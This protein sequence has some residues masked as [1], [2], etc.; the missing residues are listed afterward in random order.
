MDNLLKEAIADAKAVRETALAN[1]KIAL[2]EA[3]TPKLQRMLSAKL[4]QEDGEPEAVE[5]ED[6]EEQADTEEPMEDTSDLPAEE[7]GDEAYEDD[8]VED[9]MSEDE[10]D[11]NDDMEEPMEDTSPMG[12]GEEAEEDEDFEEDEDL[13][14]EDELPAEEDEEAYEDDELDLEAIIR[15][16]EADAEEDEEPVEEQSDSSD[17]GED[18]NVVEPAEG[19]DEEKDETDD[20][21]A[22]PGAENEDDEVVD[23]LDEGEEAEEDEEPLDLESIIKELEDEM[24]GEEAEEDE[25]PAEESAKAK[26]AKVNADLAE[27]RKVVRYL[28]S[29]LHEVNLLNAKLLYTNKLFRAHSLKEN[30]KLRVIETFDRAKN[31]REVKLVFTTMAESFGSTPGKKRRMTESAASRPTASTKPSR[32]VITEGQVLANRFKKL[33]G[34]K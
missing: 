19:D 9:G 7:S 32:K 28:S 30:Q 34:I 12:E 22:A 18:D 33:A 3:F 14:A 6:L 23:D 10:V 1:A 17:I 8:G 15:E 2:E 21:S 31:L 4:A 13:P 26:L 11:E 5:D 20:S 29:K 27:H 24:E 25:E 16:L